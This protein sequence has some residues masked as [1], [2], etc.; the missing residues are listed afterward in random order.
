MKNQL[1]PPGSHT[2]KNIIYQEIMYPTIFINEMPE[3]VDKKN[4]AV[5]KKSRKCCTVLEID[6][7]E[8]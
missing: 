2:N 8:M 4:A 1:Q 3:T 7:K 6:F 5:M